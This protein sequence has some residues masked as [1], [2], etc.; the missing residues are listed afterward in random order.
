MHICFGFKH[1]PS[2]EGCNEAI[3]LQTIH[4]TPQDDPNGMTGLRAGIST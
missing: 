3:I 1:F 2:N 4:S